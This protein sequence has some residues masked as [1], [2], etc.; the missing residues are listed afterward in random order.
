[1]SQRHDGFDADRAAGRD[2]AREHADEQDDGDGRD[3]GRGI[4]WGSIPELSDQEPVRR[5]T[6]CDADDQASADEPEPESEHHPNHIAAVAPERHPDRNLP[7]LLRHGIGQHSVHPERD[8]HDTGAGK[9]TEHEHAEP[10]PRIERP[11]DQVF[12]GDGLDQRDP[13]VDGLNLSADGV[14]EAHR[15]V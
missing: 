13:L 9:D 11:L 5:Q 15:I 7:R 14:G 6:G 12:E 2:P 4:V 10:R 8:Q 1:M 3:H